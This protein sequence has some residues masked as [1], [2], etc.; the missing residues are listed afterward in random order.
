MLNIKTQRAM[1]ETKKWQKGTLKKT[2]KEL[3]RSADNDHQ[4]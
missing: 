1:K 2:K 3:A 4:H